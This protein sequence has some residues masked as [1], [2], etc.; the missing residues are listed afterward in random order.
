MIAVV[1]T[2]G[3]TTGCRSNDNVA[4]DRMAFSGERFQIAVGSVFLVTDISFDAAPSA[5]LIG[6]YLND[7]HTGGQVGIIPTVSTAGAP[8]GVLHLTTPLVIKPNQT[9][10]IGETPHPA[11]LNGYMIGF[12]AKEPGGRGAE[13]ATMSQ[14]KTKRAWGTGVLG[15]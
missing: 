7:P 3:S 1:R 5:N 11:T 6:L 12:F 10:C 8:S 13:G 4:L 14:P 15:R 2:S 9:L